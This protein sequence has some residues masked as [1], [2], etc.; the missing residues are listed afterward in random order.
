MT[1]RQ[2]LIGETKARAGAS[3]AGSSGPGRAAMQTT[4]C[5]GPT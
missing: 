5:H 3:N 2:M 4:P 1:D